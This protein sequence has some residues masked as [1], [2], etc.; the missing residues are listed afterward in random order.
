MTLR[1]VYNDPKTS[2]RNAELLA[3]RAGTSVKSAKAF[4]ATQA[5]AAVRTAWRKPTS[6]QFAPAGG[7]AGHWQVDTLFLDDY[8]GVNSKRR[9]ILTLL[10]TTTRYA[11]ARSLLNVKAATVSAAMEDILSTEKPV[12]T[13]LRVDQGPE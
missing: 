9:A 13:I 10:N 11:I 6:E 4:L 2:T 3:K 12:I 1:E 7:P 8:R 5:S